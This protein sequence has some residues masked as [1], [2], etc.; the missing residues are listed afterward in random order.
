MLLMLLPAAKLTHSTRPGHPK[1]M[2]KLSQFIIK[3]GMYVPHIPVL[4]AC[5]HHLSHIVVLKI[6]PRP[7]CPALLMPEVIRSIHYPLQQRIS[8]QWRKEIFGHDW[9]IFNQ[10][11]VPFQ[12]QHYRHH[13]L[14]HPCRHIF[15]HLFFCRL[16]TSSNISRL[17]FSFA[18]VMKSCSK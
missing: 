1:T 16:S 5:F 2:K 7:S 6:D 18:H 4:D 15:L 12:H 9:K 17:Q 3:M 11:H 13:I 8:P 14:Y 10:C